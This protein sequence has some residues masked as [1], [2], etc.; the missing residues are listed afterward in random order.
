MSFLQL[1][2][3]ENEERR[4]LEN[5]ESALKADKDLVINLH[6]SQEMLGQTVW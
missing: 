4:N 2:Q 5:N 3:V 6:L 1:I